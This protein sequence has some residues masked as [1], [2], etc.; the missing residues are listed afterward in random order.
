MTLSTE[1]EN[2]QV[3]YEMLRPLLLR[4]IKNKKANDVLQLFEQIRKNI[5][6]N[7]SNDQLEESEKAEKLKKLKI[8][9]YNGLLKDLLD[10]K[11]YQLAQIIYSEKMREKFEVSVE[12]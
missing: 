12:D 11:S 2:I 10:V 8:D 9:F 5:K 6:L 3:D 4:T 7:K 1:T